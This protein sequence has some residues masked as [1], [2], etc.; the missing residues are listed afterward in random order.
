M[1]KLEGLSLGLAFIEDENGSF[2]SAGNK[3][4]EGKKLNCSILC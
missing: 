3:I 2:E 4:K 1:M